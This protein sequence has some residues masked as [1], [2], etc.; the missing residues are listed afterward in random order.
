MIRIL[1]CLF[2]PKYISIWSKKANWII[3]YDFEEENKACFYKI[4]YSGYRALEGKVYIDNKLA[5]LATKVPEILKGNSNN[6]L[7]YKVSM[8]ND[9]G[10]SFNWI[11]SYIERYL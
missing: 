7:V 10:K 8:F 5:S 2:F 9:D 6:K 1:K 11:A 4:Q 3:K